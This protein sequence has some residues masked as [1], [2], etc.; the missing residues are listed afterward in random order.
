MPVGDRKDP[1]RGYNFLVEIDGITRAGFREC[2]GLDSTQDPIEYREGNEGLTARK[3]PGLNKYSNI[4]LK[5][6]ITDDAELWDWR[7]QV[8]EGNIDGARKNGSIILMDDT[9]EEKVRWNFRE[10]W[11]TKWTGPSFNATGSD[12]GIESLDIVHEGLVKA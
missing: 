5:W 9:G 3:L 7:Q 12:I 1:Y 11:P 10:G 6:G 8:M 2:A 4:S